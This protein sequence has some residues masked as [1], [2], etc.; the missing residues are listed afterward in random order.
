MTATEFV[1]LQAIRREESQKEA[2]KLS[3]RHVR[4]SQERMRAKLVSKKHDPPSSSTTDLENKIDQLD[5]KIDELQK[6]VITF[7]DRIE[8]FPGGDVFEKAKTDYEE[9][10]G[11]GE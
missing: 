3:E 8:L 5:K 6:L 11:Q 1:R 2:I 4:E 10:Q 9:N 7:L